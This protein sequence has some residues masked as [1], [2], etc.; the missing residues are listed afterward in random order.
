[1]IFQL[2]PSFSSGIS[3]PAMPGQTPPD[4]AARFRQRS[5][6]TSPHPTRGSDPSHQN[7]QLH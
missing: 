2:K 4:F 7:P 1:M 6:W 5:G 3:Q